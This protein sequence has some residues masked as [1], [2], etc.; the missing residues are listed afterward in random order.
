MSDTPRLDALPVL[1]PRARRA[2][3][4]GIPTVLAQA[5][6]RTAKAKAEDAFK[7]A[8]WKRD[9]GISRASGKPVYHAHTDPRQR[10]EVAHLSARSTKPEAKWKPENGILLTAEEHKLSDA[11][12]AGGTVLLEIRGT[13]ARKALTFVRRDRNGKV[14]WKRSSLPQEAPR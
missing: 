4:K 12:T 10:G 13:D 2:C 5:D 14:L 1:D 6:K 9:G 7:E 3:P 11:R 8:V